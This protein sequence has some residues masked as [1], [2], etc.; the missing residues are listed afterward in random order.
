MFDGTIHPF[1][2]NKWRENKTSLKGVTL[3][4]QSIRACSSLM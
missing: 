1:G 4:L 2:S 3:D